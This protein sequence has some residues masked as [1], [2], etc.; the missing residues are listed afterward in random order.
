MFH[1]IFV[2]A[3]AG[4]LIEVSLPKRYLVLIPRIPRT[5]L[6]SRV[7]YEETNRSERIG[8]LEKVDELKKMIAEF[9]N[10]GVNAEKHE[11]T[12]SS[13]WGDRN[14][15]YGPDNLSSQPRSLQFRRGGTCSI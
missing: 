2:V 8:H 14:R 15:L 11:K 3:S 6:S 12:R 13:G 10:P 5:N 1:S 9:F 7:L 4:L